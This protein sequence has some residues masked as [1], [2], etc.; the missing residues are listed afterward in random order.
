MRESQA[1]RAGDSSRCEPRASN[2]SEEVPLGSLYDGKIE[3]ALKFKERQ[4]FAQVRHL[5]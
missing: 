5:I 1:L 3:I 4:R 2:C